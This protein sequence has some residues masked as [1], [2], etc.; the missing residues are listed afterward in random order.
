[1][2]SIPHEAKSKRSVPKVEFAPDE[3]GQLR[4]LVEAHDTKKWEIVA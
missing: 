1:M 4:E 3:E 2:F